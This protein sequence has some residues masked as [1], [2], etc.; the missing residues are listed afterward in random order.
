LIALGN[1]SG[2][3]TINATTQII[4]SSVGAILNIWLALRGVMRRAS[5]LR[6]LQL[7]IR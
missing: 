7:L 6:I 5:Y 2:P 1:L 3:I 4:K